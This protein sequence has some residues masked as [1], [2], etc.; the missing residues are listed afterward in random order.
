[1]KESIIQLLGLVNLKRSETLS[2][3]QLQSQF[4]GMFPQP[5]TTIDT[6]FVYICHICLFAFSWYFRLVYHVWHV[7]LAQ[8]SGTKQSQRRHVALHLDGPGDRDR[9]LGRG[10][11]Q[12]VPLPEPLRCGGVGPGSEVR[13]TGLAAELQ[14]QLDWRWRCHWRCHEVSKGR[15]HEVS[16]GFVMFC[17]ILA[18]LIFHPQKERADDSQLLI[19]SKLRSGYD[20]LGDGVKP[21]RQGGCGM[22]R[23]RRQE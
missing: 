16:K 9:G 2:K 15:C 1:M 5:A 17:L 20:F 23:I 3:L 19:G 13:A 14:L 12:S 8:G 18:F 21:T 4:A 6:T 22:G 10:G 11:P 7:W